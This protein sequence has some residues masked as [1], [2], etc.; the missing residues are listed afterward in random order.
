M[1]YSPLTPDAWRH[2]HDS[3]RRQGIVDV[4]LFGHTGK[5]LKFDSDE[6]LKLSPT[7]EAVLHSRSAL[8]FLN[9]ELERVGVAVGEDDRYSVEHESYWGERTV[10]WDMSRR[11]VLQLL[12]L[13]ES[14]PSMVRGLTSDWLSALYEQTDELRTHNIDARARA[15]ENQERRVREKAQR[16][17]RWAEERGEVHWRIRAALGNVER[18]SRSEALALIR[19]YFSGYLAGRIETKPDGLLVRWQCVVYFDFIAG[20]DKP[21]GVRDAYQQIVR[22]GVNMGQ[23]DAF[24]IISRYL[25]RLEDAGYL[26]RAASVGKFPVFVATESGARW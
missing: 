10:V 26:E 6:F 24:K 22:R 9:P 16:K 15:A 19:G 25:Y 21:F 17:K 7:H 23:P 8:F 3:Y 18:W 11:A 4:W 20:Y 2:R 13:G 14:R 1:Q 5:Q 12:P